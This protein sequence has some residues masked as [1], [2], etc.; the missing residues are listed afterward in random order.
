M[1]YFDLSTLAKDLKRVNESRKY[2]MVRTM[3]GHFMEIL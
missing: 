2:W 1:E 3:G